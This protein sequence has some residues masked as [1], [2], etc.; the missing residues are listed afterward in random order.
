MKKLRVLTIILVSV[1]VSAFVLPI[2]LA[3]ITEQNSIYLENKAS[4]YEGLIPSK[5][6]DVNI[7]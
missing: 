7:Q 1:F 3:Q 6:V 4:L 2:P 5:P